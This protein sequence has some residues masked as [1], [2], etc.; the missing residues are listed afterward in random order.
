MSIIAS[1]KDVTEIW[2]GVYRTQVPDQNPEHP[3][4]GG[5]GNTTIQTWKDGIQLSDPNQYDSPGEFILGIML[6]AHQ[7]LLLRSITQ[8]MKSWGPG[9]Q[10]GEKPGCQG[11]RLS[12][13]HQKHQPETTSHN[14]RHT[15]GPQGDRN[16]AGYGGVQL[17][18]GK[19]TGRLDIPD[20][21]AHRG[22]QHEPGAGAL[23]HGER[24]PGIPGLV[25]RNQQGRHPG[26][27]APQE[28]RN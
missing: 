5:S 12:R 4:K 1:T 22:Q 28:A 21:R 6:D 15:P 7:D 23:H 9:P 27:K 2:P 18:P 16:R 13:S 8:E 19:R 17:P 20:R 24:A 25:Q 26:E 10:Q 11:R 3:R 14:P